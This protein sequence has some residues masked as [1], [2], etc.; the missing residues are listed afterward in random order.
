MKL[1]LTKRTNDGKIKKERDGE[2]IE[3]NNNNGRN[4]FRKK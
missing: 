2:K 1:K 3:S 4:I